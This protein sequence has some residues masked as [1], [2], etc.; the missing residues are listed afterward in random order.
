MPLITSAAYGSLISGTSTPTEKL[1]WL[2][3]ERAR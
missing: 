3:S 2:R 1:R